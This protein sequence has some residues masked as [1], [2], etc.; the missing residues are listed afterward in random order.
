MGCNKLVLSLN[1]VMRIF[2]LITSIYIAALSVVPC[3]DGMPQSSIH[4]DI[5]VSAAEHDHDHSEHQDDC[6]PFCVCAC[7]GSIVTLPT[8]KAMLEN[9]IEISTDYLFH[10]TFDYSFDYS[11]GVWHPPSLS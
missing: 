4:T 11:E 3:T 9:K 7:C 8:D 6:T 2:A 1:S 5:E 10:Y